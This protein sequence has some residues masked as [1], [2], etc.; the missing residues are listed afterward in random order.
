LLSPEGVELRPAQLVVSQE[1][2][3]DLLHLRRDLGEPGVDR[4][5]LDRVPSV[6]RREIFSSCLYSRF[7]YRNFFNG[8]KNGKNNPCRTARA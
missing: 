7:R 5:L 8:G 2:F 4:I 3:F 1:G 6:R